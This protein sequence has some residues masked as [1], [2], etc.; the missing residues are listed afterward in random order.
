MSDNPINY[1]YADGS[2]RYPHTTMKVRDEHG[3]HCC[4]GCVGCAFEAGVRIAT[5]LDSDRAAELIEAG[6]AAERAAIV[7]WLRKSKMADVVA[8]AIERGAHLRGEEG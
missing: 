4:T 3:E 7:A 5:K 6:R 8:D 1:A 2:E